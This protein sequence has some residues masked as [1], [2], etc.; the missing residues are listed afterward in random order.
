MVCNIQ[1]IRMANL[2]AAVTFATL[3]LRKISEGSG[4]SDRTHTNEV[5]TPEFGKVPQNC[6]KHLHT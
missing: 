1:R 2:L 6:G 5:I 4:V 3:A